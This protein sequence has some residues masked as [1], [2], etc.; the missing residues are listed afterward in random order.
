M[1]CFTS[2]FTIHAARPA[3]IVHSAA[4]PVD[5]IVGGTE[6]VVLQGLKILVSKLADACK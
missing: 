1:T 5:P 3:V 2:A 4:K 6:M